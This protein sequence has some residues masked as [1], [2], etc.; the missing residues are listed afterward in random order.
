M[1]VDELFAETHAALCALAAVDL[2]T[3]DR[4]ALDRVMVPW[5][6]VRSFCDVYEV[7]IARRARQLGKRGRSDTAEGL[8]AD[9]GRRPGREARA[10]VERERACEQMPGLEAALAAGDVSA[11][12][13]DGL[14]AA[15]A[16][17]DDDTLAKFDAHS[18]ELMSQAKWQPVEAFA[19]DCR[20]L[21]RNLSCDEG[22]SLLGRQKQQCRVR[23]WIDRVTGMHHIHAE[24]DPESGAKAWHAINALTGALRRN[25][26]SEAEATAAGGAADQADPPAARTRA[27]SADAPS[28]SGDD[29]VEPDMEPPPDAPGVPRPDAEVH[30]EPGD[31]STASADPP[32]EP[33]P[34]PPPSS[35]K[36]T[37]AAAVPSWDLLAAQ[38]MVELLTGARGLDPRVPE[39]AVHIDVQTLLDGLHG[40]SLC[41]TSDGTLLPPSTVRRLCCRAE[42]I[43]VVLDGEGEVL[44]VGRSRRLAGRAQRR[45]LRA[46]YRTCAHPECSTEFDHCEIHHVIPWERGG[47]TDV[48]NLLPLCSRHH[49]LV[50]EGG[51]TMHLGPHRVITLVRPD[52]TVHHRGSTVDRTVRHPVPT[53]QEGQRDDDDTSEPPGRRRTA[54]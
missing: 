22:E 38:A 54:A 17:L 53:A 48:D 52:G 19:R 3:C 28:F 40:H 1:D 20:E 37:A 45:A 11:S 6:R 8:L 34:V 2:D 12:H 18:D 26:R 51:W 50:H 46:M 43:P 36:P 21:A 5:R 47:P 25:A 32:P 35:P 23:R 24:L 10:V 27:A 29:G 42:V 13:V 9:H 44:D 14:A 31:S 16:G 39:V 41:E 15:T 4:E 33:T 49:H 7:R 30:Q